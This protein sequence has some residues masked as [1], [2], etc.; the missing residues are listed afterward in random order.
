MAEEPA[1]AEVIQ[2]YPPFIVTDEEKERWD[3]AAGIAN[4]LFGD[5]GEAQVWASTRAIYNSDIP[6]NA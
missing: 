4:E 5:Q 2:E 6:T 1:Q 3:A